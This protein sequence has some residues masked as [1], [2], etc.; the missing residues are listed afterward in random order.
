MS[1]KIE[2]NPEFK[3]A[4]HLLEDTSLSVFIT[5]KAG[6]GKSTLLDYFR[7]TTK[8]SIAVLAPTG[9]AALNVEGQTIH[10]FFK[11]KPDITPSEAVKRAKKQ[12][13]RIELFKKLDALVIDEISM[14]RADLLDCVDLFLRTILK[15]KLPFGGLQIIFIGDL[16]QLPPVVRGEDRKLLK[17]EYQSPYFFDAK[18]MQNLE[19]EFLEL[20]KVYRQKDKNFINLLNVIRNNSVKE[21]NIRLLNRSFQSNLD[22]FGKDDYI[23]LTT[24]N[25]LA[26]KINETKLSELKTKPHVLIGEIEGDFTEKYLPTDIE[27]KLREGAQ[28]M[29]LNNDPGG[30]WVNGTIGKIKKIK[31]K[32][33]LVSPIKESLSEGTKTV[34]GKP[35]LVEPFTWEIYETYYNQETRAIGKRMVGS[36]AQYPLKLAWAITIHKSQGKTFD[37]VIIDI[38]KGTFTPGQ[39][40]VAL[41]RCR[42]LEGIILKKEIKKSNVFIDWRVIKFVTRYQYKLSDKKLPLEEKIE[43]INEA[44]KNKKKI[45]ITYLKSK[46]IKSKRI[47]LPRRIGKMEYLGY[48][49]MGL[50]AYCF[51][52]KENRIFR[53]D[54]ILELVNRGENQ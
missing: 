39:L 50:E 14:V 22:N 46:D 26:A 53:V 18:A 10:S 4:L 8:K 44:I 38:G 17:N 9:V 42:T 36:F 2:L 1:Q 30:R 31:N 28:V 5:G 19:M 43:F 48:K 54:K 41:S 51:T 3:K 23:Y 33:L 7:N 52:R 16:Y 13:K 27:L 34:A 15:K 47:I 12:K 25:D 32:D 20:E 6:T 29:F 35:L 11:F 49:Y 40:Y 37:K 24:I 21:E 45:E